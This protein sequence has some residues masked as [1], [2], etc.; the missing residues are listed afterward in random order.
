MRKAKCRCLLLLL[1]VVLLAACTEQ[2]AIEDTQGT[3]ETVHIHAY[4]STVIAPTYTEDGYTLYQCSTCQEEYRD[5]YTQMPTDVFFAGAKKDYLQPFADFSR[6]R[7]ENPEFV[8]VHFTS[9]VVLSKKDP[10]NM[11][12]IRSIFEDYKVSVHYI[13]DRDGSIVCYMPEERV[14]YHAGYGTWKDDPKYTDNLNEYSI[15][16]EL[17]AIGSQQD[18]QQYLTKAEYEKLSENLIGF[19]DAQ[20]VSLKTLVADICQRN[21][22][23]MDREHVIGHEEYSA[24]KTDPGELF[25]WDRL[26]GTETG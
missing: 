4:V 3:S 24:K 10:Y 7:V 21:Q 5:S 25:D 14:A 12:T 2:V 17:V 8:M 26:L 18:M 22:I 6:K 9:A 11:D 16:I 20:Y 13:I 1:L 15:G 19:T 23:P